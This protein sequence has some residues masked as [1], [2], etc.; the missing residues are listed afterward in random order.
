MLSG[1]APAR[2]FGFSLRRAGPGEAEIEMTVSQAGLN[3]FGT[4][5]GGVLFT[6]ADTAF[7]IACNSHGRQSVAQ[8][9]S[10]TFVRPVRP[11]DR[12]IAH[13]LER[14]R[15]SRTAIYDC[16][17]ANAADGRIVAEFRGHSRTIA[18]TMPA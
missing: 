3:V 6:L 11:G 18:D 4:C 9:C 12:L 1:D 7:S 10:I 8:Q 13:A 16:T 17:V 2:A 14:C 5:H 15:T